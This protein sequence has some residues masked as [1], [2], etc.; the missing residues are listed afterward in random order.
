[1]IRYC[2]CFATDSNNSRDI[3]YAGKVINKI[4]EADR[5]WLHSHMQRDLL[6][7]VVYFDSKY[8]FLIT[9]HKGRFRSIQFFLLPTQPP[10]QSVLGASTFLKPEQFEETFPYA[11]SGFVCVKMGLP[12]GDALHLGNPCLCVLS[13]SHSVCFDLFLNIW[14]QH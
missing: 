7:L 14:D 12:V 5:L 1:M 9:Q 6:L 8:F 3:L 11:I 4:L 13:P 2:S 10:P